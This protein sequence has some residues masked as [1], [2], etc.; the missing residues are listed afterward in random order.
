MVRVQEGWIMKLANSSTVT[1]DTTLLAFT[2]MQAKVDLC[3]EPLNRKVK[4]T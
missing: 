1:M 4:L 3:V 2:A